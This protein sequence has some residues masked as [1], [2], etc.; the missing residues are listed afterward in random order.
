MA[1][2]KTP[3]TR[4]QG[5]PT[6]SPAKDWREAVRRHLSKVPEVDAV[7]VSTASA[8]VH[9]YSVV[10]DFH[11]TNYKRLI[12][13]EDRVEEEFPEISFEFHTRAHQGRKPT[14]KEPHAS[15]LVYLRS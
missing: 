12:R 4:N 1:I 13:Q 7:Y 14:G 11:S 6:K 3:K 2:T 9:V 8:T 15:E 5:R 10:E